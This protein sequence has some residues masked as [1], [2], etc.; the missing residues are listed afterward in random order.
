MLSYVAII[1]H[2]N[3]HIC[4]HAFA[5]TLDNAGRLG[6]KLRTEITKLYG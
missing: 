3:V 5:N 2:F 4:M 6:K 1:S